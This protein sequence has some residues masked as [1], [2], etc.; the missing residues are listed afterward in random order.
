MK[1]IILILIAFV[2]LSSC[3]KNDFEVINETLPEA[4][5]KSITP[6]QFDWE[7]ADYMPTPPGT[8]ILS[9]FASGVNTCYPNLYLND[10]KKS[11]GWEL[12]YNSFSTSGLRDPLFFG[13]YNRYRG[14]L[15]VFFYVPARAPRPSTFLSHSV[16]IYNGSTSLLNFTDAAN[17]IKTSNNIAI[18]TT[19]QPYQLNA[20]GS[21]CAAEFEM[22]YDP[23]T[24][25]ISNDARMQWHLKSV[26]ISEMKINGESQGTITGSI[27]QQTSPP[28]MFNTLVSGMLALEGL[29]AL[30]Y[31]K[32]SE[33]LKK[34]IQKGLDSSLSGV[35]KNVFS[36]ISG[37]SSTTTYINMKT[38]ANYNLT[39]LTTEIDPIAS[40]SMLITGCKDQSSVI[41][42]DANYKVPMGVFGIIGSPKVK[43]TYYRE[44]K[45]YYDRE[46][47]RLYA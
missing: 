15:R 17:G 13:L 9:P 3:Q 24:P 26:N 28:N 43:G 10:L 38:Q 16:S 40:P 35:V 34:P 5:L 45:C 47:K 11:D 36:I 30:K 19:I 27:T 42:V 2:I 32:L 12:A 22:C 8:T 29:N 44:R 23:N 46:D 6:D 37:G 21:W 31:I 20:T 18:A 7:K 39:G 1:Q 4:K 25:N 33:N 41:G 14:I